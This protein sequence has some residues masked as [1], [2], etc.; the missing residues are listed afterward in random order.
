[1]RNWSFN[2]DVLRPVVKSDFRMMRCMISNREEYKAIERQYNR[3]KQQRKTQTLRQLPPPEVC[4]KVLQAEMKELAAEYE[5][6]TTPKV[7]AEVKQDTFDAEELYNRVMGS[8][9]ETAETAPV[10]I[11]VMEESATEEIELVPPTEVRIGM[12][13][14]TLPELAGFFQDEEELEDP[15]VLEARRLQKEAREKRKTEGDASAPNKR[16]QMDLFARWQENRMVEIPDR[17]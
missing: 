14:T 5:K 8:E 9:A 6:L 4:F 1:M 11:P 3:F 17:N 2:L 7:K 12:A 13:P 16:Q 10:H 15:K